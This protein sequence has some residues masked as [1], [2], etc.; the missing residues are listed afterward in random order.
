MILFANSSSYPTFNSTCYDDSKYISIEWGNPKP[1]PEPASDSNLPVIIG[2]LIGGIIVIG[3]IGFI[4]WRIK[5]K[6]NKSK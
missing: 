3:V 4:V 5:K 1:D 2:A 6:C